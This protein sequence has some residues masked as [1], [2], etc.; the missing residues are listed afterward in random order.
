MASFGDANTVQNEPEPATLHLKVTYL[1]YIY[2]SLFLLFITRIV[3]IFLLPLTDTT[4]SRYGEIARK[5]IETR[6]FITPQFDYGIPFWGKPPL[7][8]WL[9]AAGINLFGENEFGARIFIFLAALLL[10]LFFYKWAKTIVGTNAALISVCVLSSTGLFFGASA[11]VMT[12]LAMAFGTTLSMMA[13]WSITTQGKA[14]RIAG[15]LFFV[16]LAIGM[17]AKGPVAVVL[18]GIP[19]FLWLLIGWRWRVLQY[20]PWITGMLLAVILTAPWY[21][22]AEQKTPGFLRYFIIGEHYERFVVSGWQGDLYGSGHSRAKGSIWLGWILA[23]LPWSLIG[24]YVL[25]FP[26]KLRAAFRLDS[27]GLRS[28]LLLWTIAPMILFTPAANILA[29]YVLPGLPA[30]ALLLT[31]LTIDIFGATPTKTVRIL[32][33]SGMALMIGVFVLLCAVLAISPDSLD[34][35]SHQSTVKIASQ[36]V[37]APVFNLLGGRSYSL[38]FY[39]KGKV[40]VLADF[41]AISGLAD[42]GKADVLLVEPRQKAEVEQAFGDR[43]TYLGEFGRKAVLIEKIEGN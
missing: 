22:L 39:T 18:T 24:G 38:E 41:D 33:G 10:L 34:L 27:A 40:Q 16:G 14:A 29:S 31:I 8:T 32:F 25:F 30:A 7:H 21:Y 20:L 35:R 11:F 9:S 42:N 28:Y 19:I 5:M 23:A 36:R 37:E 3:A 26:R 12:D 15:H 4:E 43:F 6:D 2:G 1:P 13:F 17:L